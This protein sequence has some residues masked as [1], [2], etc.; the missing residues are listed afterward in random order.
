MAGKSKLVAIV[1]CVMIL[2]LV[3]TLPVFFLKPMGSRELAGKNVVVYYQPD[4]EKGARELYIRLD[5]NAGEIRNK[6]G[7]TSHKPTEVYV[8][9]KQ[10]QLWIRKWGILSRI[11]APNWYIGDNRGEKVLIVSPS[12]R[13]KGNDHDNILGASEHELVHTINYQI[14]P[15]L[16]Y[17]LDNGIATYL[18]GQIPWEGF[19]RTTA[20]PRFSD[21][22][23]ENQIKFGK[24]GGYQFS[25]T[26]IEYIDKTYGWKTVLQLAQGNKTYQQIFH[27]SAYT[28]YQ[29]WVR[30]VK[31]KYC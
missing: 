3:Q 11:I 2:A 12:A 17:W 22:K 10:P 25:Y 14:N 20:I 19:A 23:S 30:Y 24:I 13:V 1:I 18:S 29:E 8:Y 5:K 7:F 21:L 27:K 4:D 31:S 9:A 6:L 16:S 26:Y 15:E 28:I